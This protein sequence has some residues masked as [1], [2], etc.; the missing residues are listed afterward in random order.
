MSFG[1]ASHGDAEVIAVELTN[2]TNQ[3]DSMVHLIVGSTPIGIYSNIMDRYYMGFVRTYL[4]DS[5]HGELECYEFQ[6]A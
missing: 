6:I 1:I 3:G 4:G 2:Q 5:L